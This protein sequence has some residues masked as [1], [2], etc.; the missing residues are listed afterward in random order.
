MLDGVAMGGDRQRILESRYRLRGRLGQ[1][2]A[3]SLY[4]AQ[5]AGIEGFS[6]V[7]T[8]A[9]LPAEAAGRE[10][11][12]RLFLDQARV[13]A[14][15][16]H[17]NLVATYDVGGS[18]ASTFMCM[19]YL[20]GEKLDAI[21]TRS[22]ETAIAMP[23]EVAANIV[24]QCALGLH[25]AHGL[26]EAPGAGTTLVHQQ[27]NPHNVLV[28]YYGVAK[29]LNTG[30]A[31]TRRRHGARRLELGRGYGYCAPEQLLGEA[32][33]RRTDVFG[34]GVIFWECLT[35]APLFTRT[36]ASSTID[37]VHNRA[38]PPPSIL[39]LDL[40]AALDFI[41]LRALA[42]DPAERFGSALEFSQALHA[43]LENWHPPRKPARVG[44]WLE[45]LFGKERVT[46]KKNLADG[47]NLE[48]ALER[49]YGKG[50][51]TINPS[52]SIHERVL[53]APAA[54]VSFASFVRGLQERSNTW[55]WS[56]GR[57]SGFSVKP[58]PTGVRAAAEP[59]VFTGETGPRVPSQPAATS[60]APRGVTPVSTAPLARGLMAGFGVGAAILAGGLL[61]G[62]PSLPG[63][64]GTKA[65]FGSLLI[66]SDPPGAHVFVDGSPI[67]SKTPLV[68]EGLRAGDEVHIS[69]AK[70]G[71][72]PKG[73]RLT[74]LEGAQREVFPLEA[75]S[76]TVV[77]ERLPQNALVYIDEQAVKTDGRLL[78]P[79]GSRRLRIEAGGEVIFSRAIAVAPGEITIEVPALRSRP[80]GRRR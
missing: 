39:R 19:E 8:L 34:L 67:G 74:V 21:L 18:S 73:A 23:V 20:P 44:P 9:L 80:A 15:L 24:Q 3:E 55:G 78:L 49:L 1:G 69:V 13:A 52:R 41:V 75:A 66:D 29:V 11:S 59:S 36:T 58:T 64:G 71:Y 45:E 2:G 7:V 4:V 50:A 79:I 28:T 61:L 68:L 53:G 33:D 14:S 76:G 43:F 10:E 6:K 17:S 5:R 70:T 47:V 12:V 57:G 62:A 65:R 60:A 56:R 32:V 25:H 48:V 38:V 42:R 35:G 31:A 37:A 72:V 26:P 54:P 51:A 46:D 27:V 22:R 30:L 63:A 77:L 16:E 40:P